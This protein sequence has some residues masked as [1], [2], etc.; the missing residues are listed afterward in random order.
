MSK[1]LLSQVLDLFQNSDVILVADS[2]MLSH[3]DVEDIEL[4]VN[5]DFYGEHEI[6]C[7]TWT[8]GECEFSVKFTAGGIANGRW[9]GNSFVCEDHEG[10]ETK[11]QFYALKSLPA[12]PSVHELR[13]IEEKILDV[14]N[15]FN[16]MTTSDLQ[17]IACV[18]ARE[19]VAL[20]RGSL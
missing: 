14:A 2:P 5:G 17:G 19:I 4:D 9:E 13:P 1:E 18:K 11:V 7:A 12:V 3:V 10:E 6:I 20:V 16:E 15:L 8:D